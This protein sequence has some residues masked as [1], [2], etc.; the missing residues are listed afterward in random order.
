M[1][2][3]SLF[4]TPAGLEV[5][6]IAIGAEASVVINDEWVDSLPDEV[7]LNGNEGIC[8][9][10]RRIE[11]GNVLTWVALYRAASEIG[12]GR[13]GGFYGAGLWLIDTTVPPNWFMRY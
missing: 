7:R 2:V 5:N 3:A 9:V 6:R 1:I 12:A 4:G 10:C 8:R 11:G 13:S